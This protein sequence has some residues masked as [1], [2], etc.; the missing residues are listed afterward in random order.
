MAFAAAGCSSGDVRV[1]YVEFRGARYSGGL[2]KEFDITVADLAAIGSATQ[3]VAE[4]EGDTV[5][6]LSGVSPDEVI[7]MNSAT[8]ESAFSI[9]FRDGVG[10][11]GV[12]MTQTVNGLCAYLDDPPSTGCP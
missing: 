12:P 1:A 6:A 11:R 4:V 8:P 3:V 5:F 9:F 10:Q 2:A 7:I